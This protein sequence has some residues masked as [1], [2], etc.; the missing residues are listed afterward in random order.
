M[1][2]QL[3]L[4]KCSIRNIK[5]NSSIEAHY[6]LS[7]ARIYSAVTLRRST[8]LNNE[9]EHLKVSDHDDKPHHF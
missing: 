6:L 4:G 7:Y 9:V 3:T 5:D 8:K 2:S 1:G